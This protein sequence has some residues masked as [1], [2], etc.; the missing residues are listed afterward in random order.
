MRA[1]KL[2]AVFALVFGV[3]C[4]G[5]EEPAQ[6]TEQ[7]TTPAEGGAM[8][9]VAF[10]PLTEGEMEVF[11]KALPGVAKAIE[12]AEYKT[13][14]I[15]GEEIEAA[16]ARTMAGIKTVA[17]VEEACKAAGTNWEAFGGT[18]N[19]VMAATAAISLDMAAAMVEGLAGE[20]EENAEMKA[21]LEKA[22]AFTS[23]VP[24]ANKQMVIQ[25]MDDLDG[26]EA[27]Q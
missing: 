15:E 12:A 6:P 26:L 14:E 22:K 2:M 5:G 1:L 25:H 20:G 24:E 9:A 23:K 17:G 18:M 19:K 3:F 10:E 11:V 13:E 7:P 16:L 4:G 27:I 8:A 21:E